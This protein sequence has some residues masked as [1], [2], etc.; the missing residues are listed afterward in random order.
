MTNIFI[1]KK[2]GVAT[3]KRAYLVSNLNNLSWTVDTPVT[4]MPLPEDHHTENI[5]VK[6]EGN[7]A[8]MD[9]SWTLTEG[10]HFGHINPTS[11][12]NSNFWTPDASES[13]LS[14]IEEFKSMFIP[15]SIGDAY[16]VILTDDS[17]NKENGIEE[18]GT[19][20][21]MSFNVSGGSPIVWNA[22]M[23][24][25][26]G[27]VVAILEADIPPAPNVVTM[28]GTTN[29]LTYVIDPFDGYSTDPPAGDPAVI[30]GHVYQLKN[31]AAGASKM[32]DTL[33]NVGTAA[34]PNTGT[35]HTITGMA[36]GKWLLRVAQVNGN[37]DAAS[38][39]YWRSA[40]KTG[41]NESELV[42]TG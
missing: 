33:V 15:I 13:A 4:P 35:N 24:Y 38:Q 20:S 16:E 34:S 3:A 29:V 22:S 36:A 37:S 39:Y 2:G 41:T 31:V 14:Q 5:L 28:S 40:T 18:E 12:G 9:L 27:N 1:V 17:Y 6:M 7:T 10:A 30:I 25:Y 21:N 23:S 42:L 19:I 26:V 8:K 11:Y 32:W